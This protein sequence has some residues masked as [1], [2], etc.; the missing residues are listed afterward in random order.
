[1]NKVLGSLVLIMACYVQA[2][3]STGRTDASAPASASTSSTHNANDAF[4]TAGTPCGV[5]H[6]RAGEYH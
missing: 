4:C 1:M 5:N 6:H 2:N 3:A